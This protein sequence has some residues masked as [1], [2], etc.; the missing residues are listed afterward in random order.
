LGNRIFYSHNHCNA[1]PHS[2]FTLLSQFSL[3]PILLRL[4]PPPPLAHTH[5]PTVIFHTGCSKSP[6]QETVSSPGAWFYMLKSSSPPH[7]HLIL[8][9][10]GSAGHSGKSS[11]PQ[12]IQANHPLPYGRR[13]WSGSCSLW[14]L[15][16]ELGGE[17]T[18]GDGD[19]MRWGLGWGEDP[20]RRCF[21]NQDKNK[22]KKWIKK[23]IKGK[24]KKNKKRIK[25]E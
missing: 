18:I 14:S 24:R 8:Q 21:W 6:R 15:G 3:L 16:D 5:L 4:L 12:T 20:W 1:S 11:T 13:F 19:V 23:I 17:V 25:K 7:S 2:S 10:I 9:I 22:K